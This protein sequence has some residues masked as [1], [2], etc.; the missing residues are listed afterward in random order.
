MHLS[1]ILPQLCKLKKLA[2]FE[3]EF[4]FWRGKQCR[5]NKL[6]DDR[7]L[8]WSAEELASNRLDSLQVLILN[9]VLIE[10]EHLP[11]LA[12]LL[13]RLCQL[14]LNGS[15][16]SCKCSD[17]SRFFTLYSPSSPGCT[18]KKRLVGALATFEYLPKII[19][20]DE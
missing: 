9:M 20:H 1:D 8:S 14:Y 4:R 19:L 6:L 15:I 16:I 2:H 12:L 7:L 17:R 3:V 11:L 5:I 10:I 13:P 18:C